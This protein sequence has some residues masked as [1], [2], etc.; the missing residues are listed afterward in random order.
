M[1]QIDEFEAPRAA[2]S[3][4]RGRKGAAGDA[5]ARVALAHP[6][7]RRVEIVMASRD[8]SDP[9]K[10]IASAAHAAAGTSAVAGKLLLVDLL[11]EEVRAAVMNSSLVISSTGRIDTNDAF[12]IF[13]S[14]LQ[15]SLTR[16]TYTRAG[17]TGKQSKHQKDRRYSAL[18]S[19]R[20]M[21]FAKR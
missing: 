9:V 8:K 13:G 19:C 2:L 18:P 4:H 11:K 17:L 12:M 1:S 16:D 6:L 15:L 5:W 20:A 7:N 10:S 21:C 14:T 3:V